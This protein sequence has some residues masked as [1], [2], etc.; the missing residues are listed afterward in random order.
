VLSVSL[1]CNLFSDSAV[2]CLLLSCCR[3]TVALFL[4]FSESVIVFVLNFY[5]SLVFVQK[6][7]E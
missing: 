6:L 2:G 1:F 3:N 7:L 5:A 4:L